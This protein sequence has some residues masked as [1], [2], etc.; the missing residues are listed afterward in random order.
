LDDPTPVALIRR[1]QTGDAEAFRTLIEAHK[2]ALF[3]VA[4]LMTR[5]RGMAEDAVQ[6]ALVEI[7]KHLPTLRDPTRLKS[8]M[9]RIVVNEVN[10]QLRMKRVPSIPIDAA[11]IPC[12]D[13]PMENRVISAERRRLIQEA[14]SGLPREQREAVVLRFYSDLSVPEIA[15]A[16]GAPEGTI[17]SRLSRALAHLNKALRNEGLEAEA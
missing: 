13:D 5:D 11:D 14:L 15:A 3:G 10:Q 4:F 16:T 6:E 1:C 9:M 8:W 2:H 12:D 7:W 17:K